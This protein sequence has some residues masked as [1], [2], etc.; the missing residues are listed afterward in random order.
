[1]IRLLGKLDKTKPYWVGLSGG[2]DSMA[3]LNFLKQMKFNVRGFHVNHNTEACDQGH[4]FLMESLKGEFD[5]AHI[6]SIKPK[7]KSWEEHWRDGRYAIFNALENKVIVGHH[8]GDVTETWIHSSLHGQSKLI[9]YRH[10]NVIRPFLATPKAEL[11]S[12]CERHDVS[13]IEDYTNAD[14][15]HQ[16]N[17]IRHTMMPHILNINPGIG[18]ML[19]KRLL[20]RDVA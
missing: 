12:W 2:A 1:V 5:S 9:P 18:S 15:K 8:L 13:W 14:T 16:R 17:Y 11:I 19:R 7:N 10:G 4:A 3:A 6:S 20:L